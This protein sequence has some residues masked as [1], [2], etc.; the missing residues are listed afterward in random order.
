RDITERK[1]IENEQRFLADVGA[2]L[3][4]TLDYEDTLKNVAQLAVRDLADFCIVDIVEDVGE[5]RRL[6]VM[7]RDPSKAWVCDLFMQVP[8]DAS[9]T[10]LVTP[11]LVS[12]QTVLYQS[13]SAESFTSFGNSEESLVPLRAADPKSAMIVPLLAHEKLVGMIALISSS[14]SRLYGPAD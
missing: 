4:S 8:L 10:S 2:A 14:K 12:R 3:T 9:H 5:T 13:I 6:K 7:S 1:R 11:V